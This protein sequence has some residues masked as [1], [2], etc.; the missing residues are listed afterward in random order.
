MNELIAQIGAPEPARER[1]LALLVDL[2]AVCACIGQA[3]ASE[4]GPALGNTALN[5][6]PT[7]PLSE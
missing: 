6:G 3:P 1:V 2:L 7:A 5:A 4:R